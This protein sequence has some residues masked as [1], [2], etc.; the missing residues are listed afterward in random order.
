MRRHSRKKNSTKIFIAVTI[1][2]ALI[3]AASSYFMSTN[4]DVVIA[5]V[6]NQKIFKSEVE[7]KLR[8]VFE[9]QQSFG[10]QSQDVKIPE[11]ETLPKE[12]IEILVKEVYLD[13]ELVKEAK[14]SKIANSKEI[15]DKVTDAK[16][17]ILRQAYIDS[18]VK[19]EVTDQ[20]VSDKYAE[21]SNELTGKKESS[22]SHIVTKSKE[23]AE[24]V[25][26]ELKAKKGLKFSEAA[27]KYS[28]DQ[29]SAEKGGD[30]GYILEDNMIKEISDA[31]ADL[32]QDEISNPIQTKFGWHLVKVVDI[33]DAKA[34]PFEAVKDNIR[35]QL[36]QDTMSEVNSRITKDVKIKIL[37]TLKEP[38]EPKEEK[39]E[40]KKAEEQPAVAAE[41][42]SELGLEKTDSAAAKTEEVAPEKSV[43]DAEK[44][45]EEKSNENQKSKK[46]SNR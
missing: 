27:K 3:F 23:D 8:N 36:L 13:K 19:S 18:L 35:D 4:N 20:K 16:N 9:G 2:A 14:K 12:V 41:P 34:L 40:E 17:K 24:K 31:I 33:R 11:L 15:Q 10:G 43:D 39:A 28:I 32:K 7:R 6:N 38:A 25:L 1:V 45:V 42:A 5:T 22:I 21:L 30:L 26:K 44:K 29:D 46:K 37:I